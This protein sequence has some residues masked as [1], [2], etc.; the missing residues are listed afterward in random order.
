MFD[1]Q[2]YQKGNDL[3]RFT[4]IS[5]TVNVLGQYVL[6]KRAPRVCTARRPPERCMLAEQM[7]C[8]VRDAK[9]LLGCKSTVIS[10]ELLS[11]LFSPK[12]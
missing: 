8:Y 11:C 3:K 12:T 2:C 5:N 6:S 7:N 10:K 1:M 9:S 4:I